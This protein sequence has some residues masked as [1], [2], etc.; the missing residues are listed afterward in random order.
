MQEFVPALAL[1]ALVLFRFGVVVEL[2]Y[3]VCKFLLNSLPPKKVEVKDPG[4]F[5]CYTVEVVVLCYIIALV[6]VPDGGYVPGESRSSYRFHSLPDTSCNLFLWLQSLLP[7]VDAMIGPQ[8][9]L[10]DGVKPCHRPVLGPCRWGG[11]SWLTVCGRL[12]R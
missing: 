9:I 1:T 2:R 6:E 12:R 8:S 3:L 4:Y 10:A 5:E 11:L 7:R